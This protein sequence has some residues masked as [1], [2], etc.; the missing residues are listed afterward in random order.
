MKKILAAVQAVLFAAAALFLIVGVS[1][2]FLDRPIEMPADAQLGKTPSF[3][4]ARKVLEADCLACHS[5]KTVLP[6]YGKLPLAKQLIEAD[7]EN[8][9][10][11]MDLE[12]RLFTPGAKPSA[13][14]LKE[15]RKEIVKD[16]MPPA[17]YKVVHWRSLLSPADKT[18]ILDWVDEELAAAAQAPASTEPPAS[19]ARS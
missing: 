16:S 6:W 17:I 7:I 13:H 15:I 2:Q 4:K 3:A 9:M 8:A 5:S 12:K 10:H 11:E 14:T 19:A 1:N 18:A